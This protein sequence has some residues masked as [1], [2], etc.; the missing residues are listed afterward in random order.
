[1]IFLNAVSIVDLAA[2]DP[3][4]TRAAEISDTRIESRPAIVTFLY[5]GEDARPPFF[6]EDRR[7]LRRVNPASNA[8]AS[9]ELFAFPRERRM[10]GAR[11]GG[12]TTRWMSSLIHWCYTLSAIANRLNR[13]YAFPDLARRGSREVYSGD[14]SWETNGGKMPGTPIGLGSGKYRLSLLVRLIMRRQTVRNCGIYRFKQRCRYLMHNFTHSRNSSQ[15]TID[16]TFICD[17]LLVALN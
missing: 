1:M 4:P 6:D 15:W 2:R 5:P 16:R 10:K 17:D 8:T 7:R 9:N 3:R 11:R 13:L 14:V 12:E